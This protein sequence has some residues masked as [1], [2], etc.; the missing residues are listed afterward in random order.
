MLYLGIGLGVLVSNPCSYARVEMFDVSVAAQQCI[1]DA[2]KEDDELS[3][4]VV[5]CHTP[6]E[7]FADENF[8]LGTH[9][10]FDDFLGK[11]AVSLISI[12]PNM[13]IIKQALKIS[14]DYSFTVDCIVACHHSCDPLDVS[15]DVVS[16]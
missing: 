7:V 1:V 11:E 15:I 4:S 10:L 6:S 5:L 3:H 2:L 16:R 13:G 9:D 14:K 12:F 8:S